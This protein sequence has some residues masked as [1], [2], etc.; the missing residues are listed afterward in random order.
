MRI[1]QSNIERLLYLFL[2]LMFLVNIAGLV[3]N[4]VILQ[5]HTHTIQL[6]E[7]QTLTIE[8]NQKTNSHAIKDYIACLL[9]INPKGNLKAQED[10]CFNNAPEVK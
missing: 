2:L 1:L 7:Q 9:V 3:T 5:E 10:T 6:Q 8:A 4:V